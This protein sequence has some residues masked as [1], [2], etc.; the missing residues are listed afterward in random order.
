MQDRYAGDVGD[1]AKF[2]L[3]RQ[4]LRPSA[5]GQRIW[6]AVLWYLVED[7]DGNFDGKHISY[8]RDDHMRSCDPVLHDTLRHI[9]GNKTRNVRRLEGS[10][11]LPPDQTVFFS[12]RMASLRSR[13]RGTVSAIDGRRQWFLH[14]LEGSEGADLV[15]LDPDNGLEVASVPPASTKANKYVYLY[16]VRAI[17]ERGQSVLIY[18][19]HN[20]SAAAD[21][22]TALALKRLRSIIPQCPRVAAIT[23]RRG[24]VRSFFLLVA[25]SHSAILCSHMESLK[26]GPWGSYFSFREE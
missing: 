17:A 11:L 24:S 6:L 9:V 25:R 8:L 4:L 15:F 12:A 5:S 3:L 13:K 18:Q 20:R 14:A 23:F 2:G 19:H 10:G 26:S 21:V 1:F 7:E 22:Q 16:E